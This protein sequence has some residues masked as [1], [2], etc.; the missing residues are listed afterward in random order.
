MQLLLEQFMGYIA[1][2]RGLALNTRQAYRRDI[3]RYI[4]FLEQQGRAVDG[5]DQRLLVEYL[6]RLRQAGL[7]MRSVAR[8]LSSLKVFYRFLKAEKHISVDPTLN[9]DTPRVWKKLPNALSI[10]QVKK[11][12]QQ[13]DTSRPL[14]IRDRTMLEVLYATGMRISELLGLGLNSLNLEMGYL[15]CYGKGAKER[16]VPMGT[17][18]A[19]WLKQYLDRARPQLVRQ[20]R[21]NHLFVNKRGQP[22]SRQGCWKIIKGYAL[23]AGVTGVTPHVL[24]HSFASHLL[25]R[26]ADLRSVQLMLGHADISTT[27]IYTH[28]RQER[29]RRIYQQFH[30]RA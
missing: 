12:L 27:Q 17:Q 7:G 6:S 15:L 20:S 1:A 14:G 4:R 21:S 13:P 5:T 9:M 16:V 25:E 8:H 11:L 2:E 19:D 29:L 3:E 24:R 26:G 28:V 22:M 18:A 30:P 10:Q 23:R